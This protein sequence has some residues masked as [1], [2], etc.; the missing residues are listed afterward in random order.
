MTMNS[1]IGN[2][3]RKA[4]IILFACVFISFPGVKADDLFPLTKTSVRQTLQ[5][6]PDPDGQQLKTE[7]LKGCVSAP[8]KGFFQNLFVGERFTGE[9]CYV[10]VKPNNTV[11]VSFLGNIDIPLADT[12]TQQ[13]STDIFLNE[14][15]DNGLIIVQHVLGDVVSVTHTVYDK[16]GYVVYAGYGKGKFI[17]SCVIGRQREITKRQDCQ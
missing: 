6:R 16:K 2:H 17:K 12:A 5:K 13:Y 10:T 9:I 3:K 15:G 8:A 14:I 7:T 4:L 1:I 11:A